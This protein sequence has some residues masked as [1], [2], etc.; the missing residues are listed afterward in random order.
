MTRLAGRGIGPDRFATVA[1]PS[2]TMGADCRVGPGS[3]LLANVALTTDATLGSH[4]VAM[5]HVTVTHDGVI[6]DF[7]TLCAGVS[8]GG[9]VRVGR[10]AYL[11]MNASVRQRVSVGE[12]CVV[13]M[14][15]VV[16]TSIAD[17]SIV[18]GNPAHELPM[19]TIIGAQR[20]GTRSG[21]L[22]SRE[23]R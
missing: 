19:R 4:V 8:L 5:P 23:G 14:G 18:V 12:R 15:A 7:A 6:E 11:G 1:H 2:V 20:S 13:G 22:D 9:A 17:G 3:V 10:G 21:G 16:L